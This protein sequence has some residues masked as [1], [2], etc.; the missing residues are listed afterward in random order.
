MAGQ[1]DPGD[2]DVIPACPK[3][4]TQVGRTLE[5][6]VRQ[7]DNQQIGEKDRGRSQPWPVKK[8]NCSVRR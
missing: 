7:H 3:F 5:R 2:A 1:Q 6:T 4:E 8:P